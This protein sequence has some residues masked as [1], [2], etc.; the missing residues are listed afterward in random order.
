MVT[1]SQIVEEE[2]GLVLDYWSTKGATKFVDLLNGFCKWRQVFDASRDRVTTIPLE[3]RVISIQCRIL[4]VVIS[5]TVK[6]ICT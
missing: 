1:L 5:R 4:S 3:Y 2:K 6:L